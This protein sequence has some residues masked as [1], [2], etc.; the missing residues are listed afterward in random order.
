[1][2]ATLLFSLQTIIS[3]GVFILI[4]RLFVRNTNAYNWNRFYL[5]ATMII[6]LFLPHIDISGW[7]KVEKPIIFYGSLI[8]FN[9]AVTITPGQQVQ[10]TFNLSDLIMTGYWLVVV[11]LLLRFG[12]G[13]MRI[14]E[15]AKNDDYKKSGNLRLYPIQRK[16]TFSFFNWIF[17]QPQ[18]WEKPSIDYIIRHE[19]AHVKQM[20]SLDNLLTEIILVFGWFNPFYYVYR[21]DLHLLHECQ[22]DQVVINSGCDTTT[23]HQLL[24]NEVSGNL[25]YI[26]VNQFSYSLIK[27]RFKMISKNKQSRLAG[28]RILLAIPTA[29]A[30]LLLFSFTSLDKTTSL[31]KNKIQQVQSSINNLQN[32]NSKETIK[33]AVPELQQKDTS[34]QNK[35]VK[36]AT[37]NHYKRGFPGGYGAFMDFFKTN[38]KFP[39]QS[40]R[41]D[42]TSYID[43]NFNVS[44]SGEILNIKIVKGLD[45]FCDAEVLRLIKKMPKWLPYL[46]DGKPISVQVM[47]H[48]G[49]KMDP[50][51]PSNSP[52]ENLGA[53]IGPIPKTDPNDDKPLLVVEQNPEFKGGYEAMQ[54]FLRDRITY[55]QT[56][57][58][59][60]IQ[61]TVFC[62]FVVEKTGAISRIKILRGIGGGCDEEA[63]RVVKEMP[64]WIPGRQNGQDVPVMFQIP[65]KFQLNKT[66]TV[67][68]TTTT[69][70]ER[71]NV[72]KPII[73]INGDQPLLVVEQNPEFPGGY[74]AMQ[75]FLRNKIQYP[76]LAQQSGI[77][78]TVFV[79][80]AVTKT[81]EISNVRILRGIGGGCDEE[82]I[83][84][85]KEMPKWI[86]GRQNGQAVSVLFQI[87]VKFQLGANK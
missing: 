15:L 70:Q 82:A 13:I 11:F 28:F 37:E 79:Q 50:A 81:G 62:Q 20:H 64:D 4:Y 84:V 42:Y 60:G 22:A 61:G 63:I 3:A 52:I 77:Q 48:I 57:K 46:S 10:N 73:D 54:K 65:V 41:K 1:M 59:S 44:E 56:A 19:Q 75:T 8:D 72:R 35:V 43:A 71:S 16:T 80:F 18:H 26:I 45:E 7:F 78:G 87:P 74:S 17:I 12:W 86:P 25:T 24:M 21:R 68:T 31:L 67:P 85:V 30:L 27:R 38:F 51:Y 76:T 40:I 39:A 34:K 36:E 5:L 55:P 53:A 23:Y 6:S 29:F 66:T 2:N 14:L 49:V 58:Q 9:Q 33:F 69:I 83:R 47:M 32:T